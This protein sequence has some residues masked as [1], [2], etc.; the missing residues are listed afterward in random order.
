MCKDS[1]RIKTPEEIATIRK[2]CRISERS[3]YALLDVIKPGITEIDIAN[4]LEYQFPQPWR[5]RFLL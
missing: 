2:A 5:L 3:F 1:R 4:E